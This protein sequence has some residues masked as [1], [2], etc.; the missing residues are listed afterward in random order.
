MQYRYAKVTTSGMK[1]LKVPYLLT[2]N[3]VVPVAGLDQF[4]SRLHPKYS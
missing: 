1:L 3:E 4:S 2:F